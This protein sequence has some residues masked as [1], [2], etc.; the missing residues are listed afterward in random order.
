MPLTILTAVALVLFGLSLLLMMGQAIAKI[1]RPDLAPR[2]LTSV[3]L[4]V[5]FFGSLNLL[6][7]GVMGEYL[8]KVFEEV[9]Q[10]PHF[11]RRSIIRDGE[12]RPSSRVRE[13]GSN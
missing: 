2:G 5:L 11:I 6:A 1:V 7:V 10:R 12:V 13:A 9:K 8:A 3:L 4:L